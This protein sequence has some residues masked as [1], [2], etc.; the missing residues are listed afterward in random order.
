MPIDVMEK[1]LTL[2]VTFKVA[3]P[4]ISIYIYI[5]ISYIV[6]I[7]CDDNHVWKGLME[8][9][10]AIYLDA[11]IP[12]DPAYSMVFS[13]TMNHVIYHVAPLAQVS[14]NYWPGWRCGDQNSCQ[15]NDVTMYWRHQMTRICS[16]NLPV[17]YYHNLEI[18]MFSGDNPVSFVQLNDFDLD[19]DSV[20]NV[21][22]EVVWEV[23]LTHAPPHP[24]ISNPP[25]HPEKLTNTTSKIEVGRKMFPFQLGNFFE[26]PL[27][28]FRGGILIFL[29]SYYI[30]RSCSHH[31][32]CKPRWWKK[33][34]MPQAVK[35][36]R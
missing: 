9:C 16:R 26:I 1:N 36:S 20:S 31:V 5:S 32:L 13:R 3:S 34:N 14:S 4:E 12:F 7:C 21:T 10:H 6:C 29:P 35:P 22:M 30:L 11:L 17:T 33:N 28:T 25:K 8:A 18:D 19:S 23:T 2:V 27:L 24:S 15:C